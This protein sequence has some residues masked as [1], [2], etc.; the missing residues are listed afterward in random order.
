MQNIANKSLISPF[1][2][3]TY[4]AV[5]ITGILMLFH[6]K[7]GGI[8]TIHQWGGIIFVLG[9]TIHILLNWRVLTLYFKSGKAK[10]GAL[11]GV[12]AMVFILLV[13]PAKED[14]QR[15]NAGGKNN[16]PFET[17]HLR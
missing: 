11:A 4:A 14:G 13:V 7:M 8:Y 16:R 12:L 15:H 9:T 10:A 6:L 17:Q 1:V 5:A 2:A 3:V